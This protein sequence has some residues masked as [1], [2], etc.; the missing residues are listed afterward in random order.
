MELSDLFDHRK[1]DLRTK[2][3]LSPYFRERVL[4]Q[5]VNIYG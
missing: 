1:V 5:A 2:N 4:N 3:E